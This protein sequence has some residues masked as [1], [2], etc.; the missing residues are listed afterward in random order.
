[1]L[2]ICTLGCN[3]GNCT[4][5]GVCDCPAGW[6]GNTTGCLAGKDIHSLIPHLVLIQLYILSQQQFVILDAMEGTVHL[7]ECANVMTGGLE[8][9]PDAQLV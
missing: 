2:A 6:S 7:Q 1:M 5:P 9:Q 4:S 8:I 3:G